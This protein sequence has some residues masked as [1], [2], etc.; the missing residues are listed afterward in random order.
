V[1]PGEAD[2]MNGGDRNAGRADEDLDFFLYLCRFIHE[3]YYNI[4][5]TWGEVRNLF[6]FA[7][8]GNPHD[9]CTRM[10]T[11]GYTESVE[12]SDPFMI[13][14]RID[15]HLS[16]ESEER[17]ISGFF[18]R[19]R[20][21]PL[22]HN[23]AMISYLQKSLI[24]GII[25]SFYD[26]ELD[27]ASTPD[28]RVLISAVTSDYFIS[29]EIVS[30]YLEKDI[31]D[32]EYGNPDMEKYLENPWFNE[33]ILIIKNGYYGNGG[34]NYI[35]TLESSFRVE[36]TTGIL[37]IIRNG[38]LLWLILNFREFIKGEP[39]DRTIKKFVKK[40]RDEGKINRL[41]DWMSIGNDFAVGIEFLVGSVEFF[42]S[43]NPTVG[44]YLFIIGSTQLLIR[45]VIS[46]SR[47]IHLHKLKKRRIKF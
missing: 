4:R 18:D 42:P 15:V 46:T 36:F 11:D 37:E 14:R 1:T 19:M 41:Y 16:R 3:G 23:V 47:K 38:G 39:A 32:D 30:G 22:A 9:V 45:P 43:Y 35:D 10:K 7:V 29:N 25:G 17:I 40:R 12:D 33:L 34:F 6:S 28:E 13:L 27:F 31:S 2:P 24:M 26:H 5:I 21:V 44:I 8:K 20:K